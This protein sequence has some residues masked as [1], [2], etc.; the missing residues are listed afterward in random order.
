MYKK[1]FLSFVF[2]TLM[3]CQPAV[4]QTSP[5]IDSRTISILMAF[6]E[7]TKSLDTKSI[8]NIFQD[9]P[10]VFLGKYV[11]VETK[12]STKLRLSDVRNLKIVVEN[13]NLMS[14]LAKKEVVELL[15]GVNLDNI[16]K[17]T[18]ELLLP[19][20]ESG[21][22]IYKIF[23]R[24]TYFALMYEDIRTSYEEN[25][26]S[27][28]SKMERKFANI[29]REIQGFLFGGV[30]DPFALTNDIATTQGLSDKV[31]ET[32][33]YDSAAMVMLCP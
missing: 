13:L 8:A 1:L 10:D 18:E 23:T 2:T 26:T 12:N 25:R 31:Q 3:L 20:F 28:S 5:Q 15:G 21:D 6:D 11:R 30:V 27:K 14:T 29:D 7:V 4:A 17:A 24:E 33:C 32:V 19:P 16:L 9:Y 22:P